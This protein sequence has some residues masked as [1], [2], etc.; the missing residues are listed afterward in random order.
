MGL[1]NGT[2]RTDR[3]FLDGVNLAARVRL[4]GWDRDR[5][6]ES[7]AYY[8]AVASGRF[9]RTIGIAHCVCLRLRNY[10]V[11]GDL[12]LMVLTPNFRKKRGHL[13]DLGR[14]ATIGVP[15]F[16]DGWL[17]F[18]SGSVLDSVPGKK[19]IQIGRSQC[20]DRNHQR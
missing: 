15:G 1:T 19:M 17:T 16:D 10:R 11:W 18:L 9:K 3:R 2:R 12:S 14:R 4:V 8:Y 7:A 13:V 20:P 5:E 6:T